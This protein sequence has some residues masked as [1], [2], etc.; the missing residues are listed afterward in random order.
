MPPADMPLYTEAKAAYDGMVAAM[1][2]AVAVAITKTDYNATVMADEASVVSAAADDILDAMIARNGELLQNAD[3]HA[4]Q[5]YNS[6]MM[7]LVG[8]LAGSVLI[9][10]IAATWIVV[11]ISRAMGSAVRL[12]NEVA[13]GNLSAS[14]ANK[15]DDEV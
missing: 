8:L 9:A 13:D 1:D 10:A 14:V 7:L 11:S 2:K 12:A 4:D 15:S 5:L 6:S 3:A